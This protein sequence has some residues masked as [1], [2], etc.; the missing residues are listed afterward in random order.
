M[1]FSTRIGKIE[2]LFHAQVNA[3]VAT[4]ALPEVM[5][6][7]LEKRGAE[8]AQKD[9]YDIGGLIAERM[10]MVWTPKNVRPYKL[11]KE[12]MDTFF[13]NRKLKG[14]VA[15]RH[16]N[17]KPSKIII[18]DFNCPLCPREEEVEVSQIHYCIS[19]S[20]FVEAI[21]NHLIETGRTDYTKATV[22]TV[23]SVGSG[24]SWCEHVINLEYEGV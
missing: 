5:A 10:L 9:L 12:L 19:V 21:L 16:S 8:Q 14:K 22:E 23:A 20:G 3:M 11:A 6:F 24:F 15:E 13:N 4:R 2:D 17:G 1:E 18:R 7:L